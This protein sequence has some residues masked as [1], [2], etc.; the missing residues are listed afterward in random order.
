MTKTGKAELP[1]K[2]EI[3]KL[4]TEAQRFLAC[5]SALRILPGTGC[6]GDFDFWGKGTAHFM[7]AVEVAASFSLLTLNKNAANG[8]YKTAVNAAGEA[9]SNFRSISASKAV[10]TAAYAVVAVYIG[11]G[12]EEAVISAMLAAI[13]FVAYAPTSA[14][15]DTVH[16]ASN[17]F[18][19]AI[20]SL[21]V[22]NFIEGE[23]WKSRRKNEFLS[24]QCSSGWNI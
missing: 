23:E 8:A 17:N 9:A 7:A 15:V 18:I 24:W 11:S 13:Q 6:Q 4:S 22:L 16:A 10:E 1:T 3:K 19:T 5:R 20:V 21:K 14:N 12:A 2:E